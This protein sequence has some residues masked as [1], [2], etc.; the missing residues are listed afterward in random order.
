MFKHAVN[1]GYPHIDLD[2]MKIID[3]TF[4]INKFN[5]E[6]LEAHCTKQYISFL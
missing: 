6:I 1:Q 3:S 4:H 5:R 2:L